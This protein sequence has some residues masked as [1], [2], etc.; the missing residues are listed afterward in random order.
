[1]NC[2]KCFSHNLK[3]EGRFLDYDENAKKEL[4]N[5]V[6]MCKECRNIQTT[7]FVG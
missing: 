6:H 3:L 7:K 1:M 2:Q 5:E 4:I